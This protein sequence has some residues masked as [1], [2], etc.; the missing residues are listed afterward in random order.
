M[1]IAAARNEAD[2]IGATLD[3]LAAALPGARLFVADDASDDG[4][5]EVAMQHGAM[6]DPR[7]RRTARAAT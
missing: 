4:T 3:A 6:V 2:R 7:G 1:A 5:A